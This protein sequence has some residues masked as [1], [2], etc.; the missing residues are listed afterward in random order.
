MGRLGKHPKLVG[1][2]WSNTRAL[3]IF[4]YLLRRNRAAGEVN[5]PAWKTVKSRLRQT[6]IFRQQRF[7]RVADPIGDA[8]RA[9]LG[10]ITVI[11]NQNEMRRF[12]A[13]ALEHVRVAARKI[14]DVARLKVV[15]LGLPGRIDHSGPHASFQDERPFG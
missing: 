8:E 15:R 11:E 13:E 14:P 5:L 4:R 7:G 12:I 6:K 9:E 2:R 3:Q 1:L 10:K